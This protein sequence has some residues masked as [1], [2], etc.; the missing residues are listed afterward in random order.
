MQQD[1]LNAL[2]RILVYEGGK[3]DNPK[4]PG[5]RTNQG[6]TQETYNAY[7][8]NKNLQIQDVYSMS[9][10]ERDDIYETEFWDRV[11]GSKLPVGVDLV[12]FDAAVNSGPAQAIKWLQSALSSP[13]VAIDGILGVRTMAAVSEV[14]DEHD[15]DILIEDICSRRLA[16]CQHLSTW[17]TFGAG[18]SARIANVQ[19]TALAWES[20]APALL[21]PDL[22]GVGGS[23]KAKA[24][25]TQPP[26][27]SQVTT[28]VATAATAAA[29]IASQAA[30]QVQGLEYVFVWAKYA[31]G[32][33]TLL[34]MTA[35]VIAFFASKAHDA[36]LAGTATAIVNLDADTHLPAVPDIVVKGK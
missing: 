35:G 25:D 8:L 30:A 21:G 3:V 20:N 4:D 1:F 22:S 26:V 31:F 10:V 12:M 29:T 7:R 5:G 33:L 9:D 19:K 24:S 2:G 17:P 14:R 36:A 32:G 11:Q 27:V 15:L 34:S 23:A 28:Q 16:F 6:V 18:W 13:L